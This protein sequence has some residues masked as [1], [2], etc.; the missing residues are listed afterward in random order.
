VIDHTTKRSARD[1]VPQVS[2]IMMAMVGPSLFLLLCSALNTVHPYIIGISHRFNIPSSTVTTLLRGTSIDD[3]CDS[4]IDSS[5]ASVLPK[6]LHGDRCADVARRV[7]MGTA[8]ISTLFVTKSSYAATGQAAVPGVSLPKPSQRP[9]AYSIEATNPP[10]LQP[11]TRQGELSLLSRLAEYDAIVLGEHQKVLAEASTDRTLELSLLAR[12]YDS[13]KS[14][15][16]N[17][18]LGIAGLVRNSVDVFDDVQKLLDNYVSNKSP[19]SELE[20]KQNLEKLTFASSEGVCIDSYM[21]IF[22]FAK[23][24]RLKVGLVGLSKQGQ[25]AILSTGS[26][27]EKER[28][29]FIVDQTGFQN[30][31]SEPGFTIYA[32]RVVT[33]FFQEKEANQKNILALSLIQDESIASDATRLLLACDES[34]TL[35]VVAP[36]EK[37]VYGFGV[38]ERLSRNIREAQKASTNVASIIL[39]PAALDTLSFTSQLQLVLGY[40]EAFNNQR[41]LADFI[42]FSSS[43][44]VKLLTRKKN[45]ISAE[46]DKPSGEGSILKAF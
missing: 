4:D 8:L 18:V 45:A 40:G 17:I 29:F 30:S 3:D 37:V 2:G 39:N 10:C 41:L 34:S 9:L 28:A 43:P 24:N 5:I 6:R 14:K 16:R 44:A 15:N 20:F 46:G 26:F 21:P 35:I 31:V 23:Q 12:L 36:L 19:S 13:S 42:W 7:A 11:R 32:N 22:R 25:D 1:R 38:K 33:P 27:S